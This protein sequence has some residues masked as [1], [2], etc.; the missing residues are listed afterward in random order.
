MIKPGIERRLC[1]ICH[2][3]RITLWMGAYTGSMYRCPNCGY[4]GPVVIETS[5]KIGSDD[6]ED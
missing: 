4:V 2:S 1:P 3:N 6:S 5:Q